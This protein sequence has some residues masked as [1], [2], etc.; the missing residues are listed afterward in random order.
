MRLTFLRPLLGRRLG[1]LTWLLKSGTKSRPLP[2]LSPGH[3][4]GKRFAGVIIK[5]WRAVAILWRWHATL[6]GAAALSTGH[7]QA[8]GRRGNQG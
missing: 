2:R 6:A 3:K 7:C 1:G 5:L 8:V 4:L